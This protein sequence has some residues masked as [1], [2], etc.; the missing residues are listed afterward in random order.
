VEPVPSSGWI[1][2]THA[3]GAALIGGLDAA[4]LGSSRLALVLV[5]MFAVTG[6]VIGTVNAIAER[7]AR[8]RAWAS[9]AL[10]VAAP[11]LGVTIPVSSVLFDGA[12]AR[13][14]PMADALPFIAP[15]AC[16]LAI[17]IAAA[18]GRR[19]ARGD[20]TSRAIVILGVVGVFGV[21]VW[22]KRHLL[23]SGYPAAQTA[24]TLAVITL[25]GVGLRVARRGRLSAYAGAAIAAIVLGTAAAAATDGLVL[26]GD[27]RVI[28]TYGDQSRDVVRL[29]RWLL[30]LDRDGSSALLGGGD[31]DDRDPDIHP[32]ALDVPGDGIDQDCDGVDAVAVKPLPPPRALDLASW[33]AEGR[34]AALLERTKP[35]SVLVITVDALRLDM[36]APGAPHRDEFPRLV[37]LLDESVSFSRAIAPAT[38]TDV[39][40]GAMLTGRL[41]P[42]QSIAVTMPE[43]VRALGRSTSIVMPNEV[44][45]H[46]GEVMIGRGFDRVHVVRTDGA[47]QDVGDHVSA[48]ATTDEARHALDAAKDRPFLVWA[49]YFDAHEHHQIDVPAELVNAVADGGSPV[50]RRYRALL[51]AI[52]GSAGELL[53]EL[54]KR[55]LRDTT[56]VVFASDHGESLREDPRLLD[57]HGFVAY[58]PLVRIPV[59]IRIPGVEPGVRGDPISL[60]DLPP[61]LLDLLGA[62]QA[63]GPL[64]GIDLVPALLDG[65]P[66][67]RPAPGRAI[68]SHEEQQW[69]VVEWPYQL[70]VKSADDLVEL[71][72]LERDPLEHDDLAKRMPDVTRRLRARYAEAPP[73][74]VDRTPD[75]RAWREHQAQPPP[76]R[77]PR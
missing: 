57:T 56:I 58:G 20:L 62:P 60:V 5:P 72:D 33:R 26:E 41:D 63:M 27:R 52:D 70:L 47:K 23:G 10:I 6:L 43:A 51:H 25:A 61:T 77:A 15:V 12:Y 4:R 21:T 37:K 7:L 69:S 9:A 35:M 74:R 18:I 40:L 38:S 54:D 67:L 17:A 11:S 28:A 65:P 1:I 71:Y 39:S 49:H 22:A 24:G 3:I 30:D 73:V 45:R 46:V 44:L 68:V 19:L 42:Y 16:W 2:A 48:P 55:G 32:G 34:A 31:C 75:G 53:D 13:T 8:D 59:A 14:L 76:S 50:E 29:W 66:L 64:D 36:L